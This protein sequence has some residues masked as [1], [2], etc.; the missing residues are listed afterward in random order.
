M[1]GKYLLFISFC[2]AMTLSAF[3]ADE[4]DSKSPDVVA[5]QKTASPSWKAVR[6]GMKGDHRY[7]AALSTLKKGLYGQCIAHLEKA[8]AEKGRTENETAVLNALLVE[9]LVR[10]G[11]PTEALA[12]MKKL[13]H[14]VISPYWR[15]L[16][17][18]KLGR[19][20]DSVPYFS[21]IGMN[22]AEYGIPA[23]EALAVA[24]RG[25]GDAALLNAALDD[26]MESGDGAIAVQAMLAKAELLLD[27][28]QMKEA[29]TLIKKVLSDSEKKK[30]RKQAI[31]FAELL[32]ARLLAK[33]GEFSQAAELCKDIAVRQ[34]TPALIRD[35][36]RLEQSFVYE[37]REKERQNAG[38][39]RDDEES[40]GQAE[41]VLMHLIAG[42]PDSPLLPEAF[43]RLAARKA[44]ETP[45]NRVKLEEWSK[46]REVTRTS[47][48]L[49]YLAKMYKERGEVGEALSCVHLS[50]AEFVKSEAAQQL[51]QE[52]VM[53]LLDE[54]RDEE[55]EELLKQVNPPTRRSL[56]EK[57][58]LAWH[59]GKKE[60]ALRAFEVALSM[61]DESSY[62]SL[63]ENVCMAALAVNE[64]STVDEII[65][66]AAKHPSVHAAL[67]YE[68]ARYMAAEHDEKA[69]E[70]LRTIEDLYPDSPEAEFSRME[71]ARLLLS[72]NP[73]VAASKLDAVS[74]E[75]TKN[76]TW[77]EKLRLLALKIE[78]AERMQNIGE[79]WKNP[80]DLV[81]FALKQDFPKEEKA[82]L[83]LKLSAILFSEGKYEATMQEMERFRREYP[84]S[85]Y[86]AASLY[87]A[88]QAAERLQTT[89]GLERSL[90]LYRACAEIPGDFRV[91]ATVAQAMLA[92]RLGEY[93]EAD[94]LLDTLMEHSSLNDDEV[95]VVLSTR[96]ASA[97]MTAG[98][99]DGKLRKAVDFCNEALKKNI[100]S[101]RRYALL[102][103]RSR[104]YEKMGDTEAALADCNAVLSETP[105]ERQ[106]TNAGVWC[107]YERAGLAAVS[108]LVKKGD[109][110]QALALADDL[111]SRSGEAAKDAGEIARR[112]RLRML[113]KDEDPPSVKG[114]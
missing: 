70:A 31:L 97:E 87:L 88:A 17:L 51:I 96:A 33:Q 106:G 60:E 108:L 78:T 74:D 46:G 75:K 29:E 3:A 40:D 63:A 73:H 43:R 68:K 85:P 32:K 113:M 57:G 44:F 38:D 105:S 20:S 86:G 4:V 67:L 93:R 23:L 102:L 72:E 7:Q 104:L 45:L 26:L 90:A 8:L 81:R 114:R 62:R 13:P 61:A 56:Y 1:Y 82:R 42:T 53:W 27:N 84:A 21:E 52:G 94:E 10:M 109:C 92:I 11:K 83:S 54:G 48:A 49:F 16:T 89:N 99:T 19:F 18:M 79:A 14:G 91:S 30:E 112:L 6:E 95:A 80:E 5:L 9:T 107:W 24:A 69:V 98:N 22:D 64:K 47:L 25:M 65:E 15:G 37:L 34:G 41:E 28:G 103:Q 76:W 100:S 12:V 110:E 55:A 36:A 58:V 59:N 50:A 39:L 77:Q 71:Q 66:N 101:V 111:A 2:S 35:L